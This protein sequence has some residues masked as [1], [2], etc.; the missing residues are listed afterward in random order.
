MHVILQVYL[1]ESG[2]FLT[3][4]WLL[5]TADVYDYSLL[6]ACTY[7]LYSGLQQDAS[8]VTFIYFSV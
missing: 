8:P 2:S 7:A 1:W 5:R 3:A 4:D 6:I